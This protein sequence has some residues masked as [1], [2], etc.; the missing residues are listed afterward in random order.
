MFTRQDRASLAVISL[1]GALLVLADAYG[2]RFDPTLDASLVALGVGGF[3]G[4]AVILFAWNIATYR[5][6]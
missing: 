2:N 3:V 4:F 6:K 1:G 5:K